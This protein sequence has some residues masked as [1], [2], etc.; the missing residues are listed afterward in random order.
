MVILFLSDLCL[1]IF[2]DQKIIFL[3]GRIISEEMFCEVLHTSVAVYGIMP[4]FNL[5][6]QCPL[7]IKSLVGGVVFV[8]FFCI[9]QRSSVLSC[10]RFRR[11]TQSCF[12]NF[13]KER[14]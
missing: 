5:P 12:E 8:L 10:N 11:R 7:V 13:G 2:L 14:C 3:K 9:V 6:F 4:P 1:Q